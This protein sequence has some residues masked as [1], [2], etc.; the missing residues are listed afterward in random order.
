MLNKIW[1]ALLI[2]GITAALC[3]DIFESASGKYKNGNVI[4]AVVRFEK[5]PAASMQ[6]EVSVQIRKEIFESLYN[7]Q[8]KEDLKQKGKAAF[9]QS[10]SKASFILTT[11]T[12]TPALWK[13]IAR[14]SG[15]ENDINGEIKLGAKIDSLTYNA[16]LTVESASFV[17]MQNVTSSAFDSAKTAVTIAL[18]LIGIMALWLGIMKVAEESG[19]LKKIANSLRPVTKFLFPEIPQDHP[20]MGAMVM[21][22]SANMLGLGNAATPFGLKAMEELEKLNPEKG[23]AT[24]SMC[25]FLAINTAGL[26]LIPA[27]AIAVRAAS[28]SSNPAIIIG[29]SIFGAGCATIAGVT[30]AKIFEK[31]SGKD[32]SKKSIYKSLF[33]TF[34][35]L[36]L[37]V[38]LVLVL[39]KTGVFHSSSG[40]V[41][42]FKDVL[43]VVS[44]IA[45]PMVILSFVIFAFIKKVK[46]YESFIE[47]AKEG[48]NVALKI[49]PYLVAMLCA[50]AIFRSGGGMEFLVSILTPVTNLIGLP[51]EA[52]PM[53]FLRPLSG[54]GSLGLMSEVMATH[55]PDSFLGVLVST[56][57]GSTETTFYVIALYFGSVNIKKTRHALPSGLIADLF[58]MLG[59]LFIVRLLFGIL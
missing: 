41:S 19:L 50:I 31:L 4:D 37:L 13:E 56:M 17:K 39:V 47:G 25:T 34:A 30:A 59:A 29:T 18:G 27:T 1:I 20:A 32:Y 42:V 6:G 3:T 22:I 5:E 24:N 49:I 54:S 12:N 55:G 2:I 44:V 57:F 40:L 46:V 26:T 23:T 15:K 52:L 16:G 8:I 58:G 9:D 36:A 48:F 7:T 35:A 51:A 10:G 14:V 53:A 28:G 38:L 45:I 11:D 33:K 43:Q 21:N